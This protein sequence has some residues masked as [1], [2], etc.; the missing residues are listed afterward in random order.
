MEATRG[1]AEDVPRSRFGL[2]SDVDVDTLTRSVSE[3]SIHEEASIREN[4]WAERG[5]QRFIGDSESLEA[6]ILFVRDG[7][8]NPR[9]HIPRVPIVR[10]NDMT[11]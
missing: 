7:Q 11:E 3:D 8:D 9:V 5:S 1:L 10:R 6:A 4:W 2:V